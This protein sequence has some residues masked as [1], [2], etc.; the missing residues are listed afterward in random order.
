M[1][2]YSGKERKRSS[3][4]AMRAITTHRWALYVC[5]TWSICFCG[6]LT[7]L[8]STADWEVPLII[9]WCIDCFG[10]YSQGIEVSF[11]FSRKN[12][13]FEIE[14]KYAFL[15]FHACCNIREI[16]LRHLCPPFV[17]FE[18]THCIFRIVQ[19]H[20]ESNKMRTAVK[21]KNDFKN[22][23]QNVRNFSNLKLS[24]EYW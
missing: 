4:N 23:F 11:F 5:Y 21:S 15:Q 20:C 9:Q 10:L 19:I 1:S 22:L 13:I 14:Q 3:P 6:T 12:V 8:I 7:F 18:R 17:G 16:L 2:A 24:F